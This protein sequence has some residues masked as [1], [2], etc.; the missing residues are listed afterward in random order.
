M[1]TSTGARHA[2]HCPRRKGGEIRRDFRCEPCELGRR[3]EPCDLGRTKTAPIAPPPRHAHLPFLTTLP[4]SLYLPTSLTTVRPSITRCRP[5]SM[6]TAPAHP[7]RSTPPFP[8]TVAEEAWLRHEDEEPVTKKNG[9]RSSQWLRSTLSLTPKKTRK[10]HT[11]MYTEK[12]Y[13]GQGVVPGPAVVLEETLQ[14]RCHSEEPAR[15]SA[16]GLT[17]AIRSHHIVQIRPPVDAHAGQDKEEGR[18][19]GGEQAPHPQPQGG[20]RHHPQPLQ[21]RHLD[22]KVLGGEETGPGVGFYVLHRQ[23][24]RNTVG[25]LGRGGRCRQ[26]VTMLLSGLGD[27]QGTR[28]GG[29]R[30]QRQHYGR[31]IRYRHLGD[32]KEGHHKDTDQW[33]HLVLHPPRFGGGRLSAAHS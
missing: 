8:R 11:I 26:S 17:S 25:R 13:L 5:T 1:H 31:P 28:Q 6:L 29:C 10:Q 4:D 24:R 32:D 16:E 22:E 15:L 9:N 19:R 33:A 21:G 20:Y 7:L 27:G 14:S 23:A 2:S 18:A 3:C 12:R 30:R